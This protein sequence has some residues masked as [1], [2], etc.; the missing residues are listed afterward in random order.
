MDQKILW[1]FISD[2]GLRN[3]SFLLSQVELGM[4]MKDEFE[5]LNER[6]DH[7]RIVDDDTV[8]SLIRYYKLG[9]DKKEL[10]RFIKENGAIKDD[11][12]NEQIT[13]DSLT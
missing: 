9:H 8:A 3:K 5:K 7:Y 12:P 2:T 1:L 11:N 6:K 10:L 13:K 4:A